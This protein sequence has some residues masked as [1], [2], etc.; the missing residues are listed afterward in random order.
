MVKSEGSPKGRMNVKAATQT[1]A[2]IALLMAAQVILGMFEVFHSDTIKL[3]LSFIA[4]VTAARFY[5]WIGGAAVAGFGDIVSW[6]IHPVGAWLPQITATYALIG[7]VYGIVLYK[8]TNMFRIVTAVVTTQC[9]ISLFVTT[10]W[11]TFLSSTENTM[12]RELYWTKVG[13]RV[14][15]ALV[16]S[17][18]Q[19]AVIPLLFRALDRIPYKKRIMES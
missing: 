19:I 3:T 10:V 4:V 16:M 17:V 9:I 15:Q 5:G 1:T 7:A 2:M 18:V 13:M 6:L 12:F 14:P 11:L 8:K